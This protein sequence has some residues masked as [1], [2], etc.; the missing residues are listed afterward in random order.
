MSCNT[1]KVNCLKEKSDL[2]LISFSGQKWIGGLP[3]NQGLRYEIKL[4]AGK[5][6]LSFDSLWVNDN[7]V[8]VSPFKNNKPAG[9]VTKGDTIILRAGIKLNK[10]VAAYNEVSIKNYHDDVDCNNCAGILSYYDK[11]RKG[12]L[13]LDSIHL[14]PD[15]SMP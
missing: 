1:L 3:G 12:Y 15:L 7:L 5:N 13:V 9:N 6:K 11:A 10:V 8:K 4:V 2:E 14:L